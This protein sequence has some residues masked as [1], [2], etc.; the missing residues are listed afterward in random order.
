MPVCVCYLVM[1][2]L[3]DP[4]DCSLPGS[5]VHGISQARIL[6]WV[7][8]SFS[9]GFSQH[10]DWTQVSCI[11]GRFI[12]IWDTR[13]ALNSS[14]SSS[15][16][17]FCWTLTPW[18]EARQ[19]TLSITNSRSLLKLMSSSS[20]WC[21]PTISSSVLSS[22][23]LQSFPA[24]RSFL[25]TQFFASGGQSVRASASTSVLSMNIQD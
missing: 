11:A 22:Y 24:S 12:T 2:W 6:E 4:I 9:R 19:A 18:T 14:V 23:C 7:A 20:W 16:A 17:Q 3:C 21:H 8:I 10:R 1:Y 25:M 15:V 13:E 5:S